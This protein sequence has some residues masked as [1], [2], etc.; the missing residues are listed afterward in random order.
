MPNRRRLRKT[1]TRVYGECVES[2]G[3]DVVDGMAVPSYIHGSC[4]SRLVF[5]RKLEVILAAARLQPRSRVLDFGCGSGIL[6]ADLCNEG[7][8]VIATD[9]HLDI[10]ERVSELLGLER[11][12]FVPAEGLQSGVPDGSIDTVIAANVLEHCDNRIDVLMLLNAKL[13]RGGHLIVSGPT[14]NRL[15]RIGRRLVGFKGDYHRCNVDD[16]L[17][18][19]QTLG[20]RRQRLRNW[21]LPGALCLYKIASFL[22]PLD[23]PGRSDPMNPSR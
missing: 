20:F 22:P 10:A 16:V 19:T 5:W 18:D 7:R 12:S 1:L 6:L 14:E 13:K 3:R 4:V 9:L 23:G 15:Y 11:V 17:A 8:T 2:I 21:P